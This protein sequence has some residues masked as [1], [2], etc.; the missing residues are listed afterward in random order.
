MNDDWR[1]QVKFRA[2]GVADALHDRLDAKELEHDLSEAFQDRVIVS[3]NGTTIFLYAG[4]RE[5]AEKARALVERLAQEDGEEVD[6]DFRRWHPDALEWRAADEPLPDDAAARAAEH[7]TRIEAERKESE[8]QGYPQY[9]VRVQF[10]SWGEAGEFAERLRSEG[11]QTVHRWH[12]VLVGANDEDAARALAERIRSE[13]PAGSEV[14]V[15]ATLK[16][17]QDDIRSPFAFLGG[18][19]G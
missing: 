14:V 5:Q 2:D 7:Q 4:D 16:E 13:A 11:L 9:E 12:H 6:I 18:L 15:E 17:I 8:E 19:G 1:V 10:P 3:R